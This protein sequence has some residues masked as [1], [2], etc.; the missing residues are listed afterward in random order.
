[1]VDL[2]DVH[3]E[4]A[5]LAGSVP[6][7]LLKVARD[8]EHEGSSVVGLVHDPLDPQEVVAVAAYDLVRL[9]HDDRRVRREEREVRSLAAV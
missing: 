8:V 5:E 2:V 1:V 7:R 4:R 6:E 9:S 3:T